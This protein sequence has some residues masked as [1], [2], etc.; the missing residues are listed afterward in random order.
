MNPVRA[1]DYRDIFARMARVF[2]SLPRQNSSIAELPIQQSGFIVDE[3]SCAVSFQAVIL[4]L[5]LFTL[6][7][8]SQDLLS[9]TTRRGATGLT[10]E[11][12]EQSRLIR[13]AV[14]RE[15]IIIEEARQIISFR[16]KLTHEYVTINN[17]LVWPLF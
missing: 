17:Q 16:N 7:K 15:F 11:Q 2:Q 12:Y 4:W 5:P 9:Y 13:S 3:R 8:G 14:E 6:R 1:C 10:V